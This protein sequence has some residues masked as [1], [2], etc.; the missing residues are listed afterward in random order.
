VAKIQLK[1]NNKNSNGNKKKERSV[2]YIGAHFGTY[3]RQTRA[4]RR[5]Y[6]SLGIH[7]LIET[8]LL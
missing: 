3:L 1:M 4:S 7:F 6:L 2:V 8:Y 5:Y